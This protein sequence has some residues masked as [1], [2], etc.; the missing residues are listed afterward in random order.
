MEDKSSQVRNPFILNIDEFINKCEEEEIIPYENI[1]EYLKIV[2]ADFTDNIKK[3]VT[4]IGD[5]LHDNLY[6]KVETLI[7]IEYNN[8]YDKLEAQ[9]KEADESLSL[10]NMYKEIES[11]CE[12]VDP[13]LQTGV[14]NYE[15]SF[16]MQAIAKCQNLKIAL[17]ILYSENQYRYE[18]DEENGNDK[19]CRYQP[20]QKKEFKDYLTCSISKKNEVINAIREDVSRTRRFAYLISALMK[21]GLITIM[22]SEYLALHTA[23]KQCYGRIYSYSKFIERL[24]DK[25]FDDNEQQIIDGYEKKYSRYLKT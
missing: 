8:R 19:K 23:M 25:G 9:G 22:E 18:I 14:L 6:D 11:I 20:K 24:S 10:S 16:F 12:D 2:T 21:I 3:Y 15:N 5:T 13:F 4:D 1:Y 17:E 7:G